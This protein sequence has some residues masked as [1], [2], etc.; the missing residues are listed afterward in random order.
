MQAAGQWD[1]LQDKWAEISATHVIAVDVDVYLDR[2]G[3]VGFHKDSRGTTVFVNLTYANEKAEIQGPEWFAD[4][5][6]TKTG[7]VE[8]LPDVVWSDI[9]EG[10]KTQA[11]KHEENIID[12]RRLPAY[13]CVS[14]SDP[15]FY[16]SSPLGR[17][18]KTPEAIHF[19]NKENIL[20]ALKDY[21]KREKTEGYQNAVAYIYREVIGPEVQTAFPALQEWPEA[22]DFT[23]EEHIVAVLNAY[24]T[25]KA[26]EDFQ[27]IV[28]Y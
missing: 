14:F 2:M 24:Y 25:S 17:R 9:T 12:T 8:T 10:K 28:T 20:A 15:N 16:H 13:G 6:E 19:T 27:N 11:K 3:E 18:R 21:Y 5:T 22:F 4:I 1:Y 26:N 23:N 7:L